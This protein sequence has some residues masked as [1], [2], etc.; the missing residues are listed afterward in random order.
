MASIG[1]LYIQIGAKSNVDS[2]IRQV[3]SKLAALGKSVATKGAGGVP[4]I[5]GILQGGIGGVFAGGAAG[6][7]IGVTAE[8]L[9]KLGS[10]AEHAAS[11]VGET[12]TKIRE[13]SLERKGPACP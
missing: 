2:G 1:D 11:K 13:L 10:V 9:H 4:G 5:G 12:V 3:E 6:E 7:A 8:A